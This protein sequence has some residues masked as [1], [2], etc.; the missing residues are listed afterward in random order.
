MVLF[1]RS[2]VTRLLL[3]CYSVDTALLVILRDL[4]VK[5]FYSPRPTSEPISANKAEEKIRATFET[6][7]HPATKYI[8]GNFITEKLI[9]YIL[10]CLHISV[11]M[12][13]Y[14]EGR[15]K[16]GK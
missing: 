1:L 6:E 16:E 2:T 3:G 5:S 13:I 14:N 7:Y 8:I 15:R 9:S 11:V 10:C 12:E 4:C